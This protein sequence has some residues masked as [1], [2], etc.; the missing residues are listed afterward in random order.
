MHT[1][2]HT[3]NI[4]ARDSPVMPGTRTLSAIMLASR[5]AGAAAGAG[6]G[7][8][9]GVGTF[10]SA[11]ARAPPRVPF[12]CRRK[13]KCMCTAGK[14]HTAPAAC[15]PRTYEHRK[16]QFHARNNDGSH[17]YTRNGKALP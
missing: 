2:T 5:P 10:V 1:H 13:R 17:A 3:H 14:M 7:P 4:N 15:A 12:T 6:P 8:S 9:R 16:Q 11:R